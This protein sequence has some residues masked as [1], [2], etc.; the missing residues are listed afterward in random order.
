MT[1]FKRKIYES[2]VEW[3]NSSKG[4]YALMVEGARRVGK[5]TIVKEFAGKEYRSCIFLDF[6]NCPP[7]IKELFSS[8]SDLDYFFFRLQFLTGTRLFAR[9][10]LIVFDEV[11]L[12][13]PARQAVKALVKDGR[14]DYLETGSLISI[15]KNVKDILI[16]SEEKKIKM[17]P[18]DLEEFL[19]AIGN[20][21]VY[22]ILRNFFSLGK[23]LG[24]ASLREA[25]RLFRLYMVIGGMPQAVSTY[26]EQ[27]NLE[28]VDDVK[29]SIIDLYE[30]DFYKIDPTGTLSSLFDAIPGELS[31]A[32]TRFNVSHASVSLHPSESTVLTNIAE[33]TASRAV[34]AS[35]HTNDPNVGFPMTKDLRKFKLYLADTGLFITLAFKDK[36]F[37]ENLLYRGLMSDKLPVNLGYVYENITAQMLEAKGD[38]LFYHTFYNRGSNHNYEIDFLISR[39]NKL[40]PIEV[41]SSSYTTHASLDLFTE[42]YHSRIRTRYLVAPKDYRKD[43][44]TVCIPPFFVPFI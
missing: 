39:G 11:Q 30:D 9:E 6:S 38:G 25:M 32:S 24:Q 27:N 43:G 23:P 4:R 19:S 3:K 36:V 10:S 28:D 40:C 1:I 17:Y 18:M 14:Y 35:Y 20:E 22:D 8:I 15:R 29:R 42:K 7:G 21:N 37:T 16:P 31:T 26:L 13:P 12:F 2:L 44:E 34:L 5:S 33:L 41:K